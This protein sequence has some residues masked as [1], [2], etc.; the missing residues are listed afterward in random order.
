[1]PAL[2]A[3]KRRNAVREMDR[4]VGVRGIGKDV[5][6]PILGRGCGDGY[7]S[8]FARPDDKSS[9]AQRNASITSDFGSAQT[10]AE[11]RGVNG[12]RGRTVPSNHAWSACEG[13]SQITSSNLATAFTSRRQIGST[14]TSPTS[15]TG[16]RTIFAKLNSVPLRH[17]E[18]RAAAAALQADFV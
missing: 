1:M 7:S 5:I 14:D 3:S 12:V 13:R 18:D 2:L 15:V 11:I 6:I 17:P 16:P 4:K 10:S 9:R 8:G